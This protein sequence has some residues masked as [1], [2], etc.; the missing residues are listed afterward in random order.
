MN[1]IILIGNGFDLAHDLKTSFN[2]FLDDYWIKTIKSISESTDIRFENEDI[3]ISKNLA[4]WDTGKS[5]SDLK[6]A[7]QRA[8]VNRNEQ[9]RRCCGIS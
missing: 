8:E 5:Y 4:Q 1:R 3:L 6:I 7:T 9:C 2:D